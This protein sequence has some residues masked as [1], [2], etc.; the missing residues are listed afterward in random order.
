MYC[1]TQCGCREL[2]FVQYGWLMGAN[3]TEGE[4]VRSEC[5]Y[6]HPQCHLT[7]HCVEQ[8]Y[9]TPPGGPSAVSLEGYHPGEEEKDGGAGQISYIDLQRAT[10][11]EPINFHGVLHKTSCK[12]AEHDGYWFRRRGWTCERHGEAR[13][14]DTKREVRN[15]RALRND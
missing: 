5:K 9:P 11:C 3:L 6:W 7:H 14:D 8:H 15:T 1:G 12:M 4:K 10:P 2:K 13:G